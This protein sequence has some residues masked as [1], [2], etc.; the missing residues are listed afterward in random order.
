MLNKR[1]SLVYKWLTETDF[2]GQFIWD[3]LLDHNHY[4]NIVHSVDIQGHRVTGKGWDLL[5]DWE[6]QDFKSIKDKLW[7]IS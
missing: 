3:Y 1:Q 4:W 5:A 7:E 2:D 6:K